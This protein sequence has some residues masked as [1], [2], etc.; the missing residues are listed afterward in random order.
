MV[1]NSKK[2]VDL[3]FLSKHATNNRVEQYSGIVQRCIAEILLNFDDQHLTNA[4]NWIR[5]AIDADKKNN[6]RWS[7]AR[8][9]GTYAEISKRK[10]EST[11]F[12]E[13]IRTVQNIFDEIGAH[14]WM[15]KYEKQLCEL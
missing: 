5:K 4:E 6:M 8:D 9:Y 10:N 2:S 15:E 11:K 12:I 13:N 7:L 3:E 1:K 14:G